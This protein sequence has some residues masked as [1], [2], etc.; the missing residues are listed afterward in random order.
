M[1]KNFAAG[2]VIFILS[3]AALAQGTVN[4]TREEKTDPL[5]GTQFVQFT[6]KGEY[7]TPPRDAAPGSTPAIVVRCI[8]GVHNHGH[9]NGIFTEGYIFV[10][11]ILNS[12]VSDGGKVGVSVQFRLDD[13]KLQTH[14]WNHS[15]DFS[16]VF[17][18]DPLGSG[19]EQFANLLYGHETYHKENT[20]PQVRKVIIGLE[21]YLESEVVMQ[22]H[23][24]EATEVAEA[25]G[26]IWHK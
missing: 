19:W 12:H 14:V 24:P 18:R 17:F 21:E 10:G 15:T 11:G 25:C 7:L 6:L 4:W 5:R 2:S 23:M 1:V 20:N 16:S 26:I 8:P 22:F 13:G 3:L 9:T